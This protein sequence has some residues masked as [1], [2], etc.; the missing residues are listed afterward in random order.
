MGNGI[1]QRRL[2]SFASPLR[3]CLS[4]LFDGARALD[5]NRH[6]RAHG[7]HRLPRELRTGDSQAANWPHSQSHW[8][9]VRAMFRIHRDFVTQKCGPHLLF[10]QMR[11]AES[12][13]IE[14]VLLWQKQFRGAGLKTFHNVIGDRV[15]QLNYIAFTQQLPAETVQTLAFPPV[16]MRFIGFFANARGKLASGNGRNQEREQ[17]HP[18]LRIA[19]RK[20]SYRR[21]EEIV[22]RQHRQHRHE[23]R[24][25]HSPHGGNC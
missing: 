17:G 21:Q 9:E 6:Q 4:E 10:I 18:I 20:C 8:D 25:G 15:H 22:E 14:F 23:H 7:F 24:R 19:N 13:A 3:F 1:K 5:G 11:G 16:L 12:G 2:Q